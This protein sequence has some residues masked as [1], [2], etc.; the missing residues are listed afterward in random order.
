MTLRS[1]TE[2]SG[3]IDPK[4]LPL[5]SVV[6]PA[7][8]EENYLAECIKSVQAQTYSTWDYTIVNNCSTDRTLAI[9][10]EHAAR[11]CR[12]RVTTN[13]T[14]I[15]A[16]A[17][18]NTAFRRISPAS[19]YC[20]MVLADDWMFPECLERMV[21]LME[22]HPSVG[23]VGAY[24][25]QERAVLWTGLPYP[26]TVVSGRE[27]CRQRLL[28]GPYVF[29]S[30][31][32]VLFR[33]DLVRSHNPFYNESNV[34]ADSEKCF[35]LLRNCDF[36][37]VH[38]LLTFSRDHRPG[39]RV[40][41][42]RE[43]NTAAV[44]IMHELITYGPFYLTQEEYKSCLK[45]TMSKYYNFLTTSLLQPRPKEFWHYHKEKLQE[46][47][48]KF[49]YSRLAYTLGLRVLCRLRFRSG[50]TEPKWGL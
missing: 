49:R 19:K 36:G 38:Q 16:I 14:F 43:L 48:M 11:D 1:T 9:A 26:S 13:D 32:S 20:K 17:N 5:V 40:E 4:T 34:Q 7:Y 28:G 46:L 27:A 21:D 45:A 47:G 12:I 10:Q 25:M 35:E 2:G 3:R 18:L 30:P 33:S 29:G 6:T 44:G 39:S 23:I 22:K 15:P 41:A 42:S 8:N 31:T 50:K 37:F 24:G